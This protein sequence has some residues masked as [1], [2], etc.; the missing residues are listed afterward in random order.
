MEQ[1]VYTKAKFC[2]KNPIYS[3]S[4]QV[5]QEKYYKHFNK[6]LKVMGGIKHV[7]PNN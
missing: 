5:G 3:L 7:K 2:V 1:K 6:D 4:R